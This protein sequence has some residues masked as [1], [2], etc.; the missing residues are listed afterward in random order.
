[1]DER[2]YPDISSFRGKLSRENNPDPWAF[3]RAQY[4]KMLL[5]SKREWNYL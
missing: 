3:R 1:M 2:E 4:V 5:D